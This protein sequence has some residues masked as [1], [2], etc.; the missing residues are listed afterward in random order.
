MEDEKKLRVLFF[1]GLFP[2]KM[3]NFQGIFNAERAR[4]LQRSCDLKV[5]ST[6]NILPEKPYREY[7]WFTTAY[8][9]LVHPRTWTWKKGKEEVE[10]NYVKWIYLPRAI[11][12]YWETCFLHFFAGRRIRKIAEAFKPDAVFISWAYPH[13]EYARYFKKWFPGIKTVLIAERGD[14]LFEDRQVRKWDHIEKIICDH[15]DEFF[16]NSDT[17][18]A[19]LESRKKKISHYSVIFN[20]YD[21]ELFSCTESQSPD[22][23][24]RLICVGYF[25][26]R[27]NQILLLQAMTRLP[28]NFRLTL[29]GQGILEGE[30]RKF[31]NENK[32]H[33]KVAI[34][35]FMS[36]DKLAEQFHNHHF[37][38]LP[39]ITEGMCI[40]AL[41]A[42]GCGLPLI[43]NDTTGLK[44]MVIDGKTGHAFTFNNLDSL[45][46]T[47]NRAEKEPWKRKEISDYAIQ[48]YSITAWSEKVRALM[49]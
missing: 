22:K 47:L 26:E 35:P 32:L 38:V 18:A 28:D 13:G 2:N 43:V 42:L 4:V 12:Y 41:E 15:I 25:I 23:C 46:E 33:D 5:I 40:V 49:M 20:G 8:R 1:S 39:S 31:I 3:N 45:V 17:M 21:D 11:G 36:H 14:I 44:D 34:I 30:Y 7:R 27:K 10:I 9:K 37:M 48:T 6:M 16:V 24:C 29:V 19:Y